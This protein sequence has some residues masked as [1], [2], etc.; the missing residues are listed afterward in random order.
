MG[1]HTLALVGFGII[2]VDMT[3]TALVL[4]FKIL[5]ELTQ[6]HKGSLSLGDF[7]TNPI[8]RNIVF[9]SVGHIGVICVCGPDLRELCFDI[10]VSFS[11]ANAV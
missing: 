6:E 4:A 11:D 10:L 2:T 9:E 7:F 5:D 8:F 1:G 3:V